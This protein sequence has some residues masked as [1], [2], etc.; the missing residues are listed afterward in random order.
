MNFAQLIGEKNNFSKDN[1][2]ISRNFKQKPYLRKHVQ[3]PDAV[4]VIRVGGLG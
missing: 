4:F 1:K 3:G 2:E